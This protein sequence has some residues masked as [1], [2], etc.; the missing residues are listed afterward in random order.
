MRLLIGFLLNAIV[1]LDE[2]LNRRE[3]RTFAKTGNIL[4]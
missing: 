1:I 2:P 4:R 3:R